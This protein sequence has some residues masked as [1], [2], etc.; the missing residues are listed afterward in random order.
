V[1]NLLLKLIHAAD[2][3]LEKAERGIV[4]IDEIDKIARTQ[5]NPS[6][7]RDVSGEGV[8]QGLLKML[9]GTISNVPP[10][11]GR[12]HPEQEYIQVDTTH[13]LFIGGG[14]F[15]GIEKTIS[16]RV[17]RKTIGFSSDNVE[18]DELGLGEILEYIEPEDM[19]EFGMI[20][21]FIG[22]FPVSCVVKP[23]TLDQMVKVLQEPKNALLRQYQYFFKLENAQLNFT[24]D[25]LTE[26]ARKA[27]A[28]KTGARA[29]RGIMENLLLD[30]MYD[31][32][33]RK[34]QPAFTITD[35]MVRGDE[36]INA[37]P[38]QPA[39]PKKAVG[40]GKDGKDAGGT[41]D[42]KKEIA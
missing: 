26:I 30:T 27:M 39:Q 36:P 8:Q 35:R 14:T 40:G 6:I 7:T 2:Y 21:E 33:S 34:D 31:L 22:R 41:K 23:L 3:D 19:I 4:F 13:I 20:P 16:R 1:E 42:T 28:K 9:E 10:Q 32:P 12:K 17:G 5:D 37:Q 29:L 11:G 18:L 38:A 25:A 24:D 15:D